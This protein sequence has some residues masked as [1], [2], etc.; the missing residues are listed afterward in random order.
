MN[1]AQE[2]V[3]GRV[4]KAFKNESSM[5]HFLSKGFLGLL[6][7]VHS[8]GKPG[9]LG[10]P[11]KSEWEPSKQ[12]NKPLNKHGSISRGRNYRDQEWEKSIM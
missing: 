3:I 11:V 5:M 12:T 4:V 1:L 7:I 2:N 8:N 10:R 6:C 9:S